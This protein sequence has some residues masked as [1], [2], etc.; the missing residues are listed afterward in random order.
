MKR[1]INKALQIQAA[2]AR[3]KAVVAKKKNKL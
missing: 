3:A 2:K 1:G